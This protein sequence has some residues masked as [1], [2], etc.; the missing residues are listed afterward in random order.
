MKL[1]LQP[2]RYLDGFPDSR[3]VALV[4]LVR[5]PVRYGLW[6]RRRASR[7]VWGALRDDRPPEEV[8]GDLRR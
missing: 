4:E 3:R 1:R 2:R 7:G 6:P 8:D 5:Y